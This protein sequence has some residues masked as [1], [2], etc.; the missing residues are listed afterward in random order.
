[1]IIIP[2]FIKQPFLHEVQR[3]SVVYMTL[4]LTKPEWILYILKARIIESKEDV[5]FFICATF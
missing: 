3:I 4:F 1:M 2:I 5:I